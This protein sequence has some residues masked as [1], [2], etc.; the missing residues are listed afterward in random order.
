[1]REGKVDVGLHRAC[2]FGSP[3]CAWL[4][5]CPV[6]VRLSPRLSWSIHFA[7]TNLICSLYV[8]FSLFV[9]T[10]QFYLYSCT[11]NPHRES[12][13]RHL[14]VRL[15]LRKTNSFSKV[16]RGLVLAWILLFMSSPKRKK[17][18]ITEKKSS[19]KRFKHSQSRMDERPLYWLK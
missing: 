17:Q 7:R 12:C 5:T 14:F 16:L 18:H 8:P 4:L 15:D 11:D 13:K 3:S 2:V 1:M 10:F 19:R 6:T 9:D